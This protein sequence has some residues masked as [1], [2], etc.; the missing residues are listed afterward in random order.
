[1]NIH[2]YILTKNGLLHQGY[3]PYIDT[4][5]AETAAEYPCASC[6]SP[7]VTGDGFKKGESYRAFAVCEECGHTEEF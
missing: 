5:D 3:E 4:F 7:H 1:M 2:E 6:K